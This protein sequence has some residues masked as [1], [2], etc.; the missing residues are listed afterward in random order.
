MEG[1][2]RKVLFFKPYITEIISREQRNKNFTDYFVFRCSDLEKGEGI[3]FRPRGIE[4]DI[5]E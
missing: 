2:T 5:G 3:E 1:I 4:K